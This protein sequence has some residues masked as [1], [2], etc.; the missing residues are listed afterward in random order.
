MLTSEHSQETLDT[1]L[2]PP[3]NEAGI[4]DRDD[5]SGDYLRMLG[6]RTYFRTCAVGQNTFTVSEKKKWRQKV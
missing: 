2:E 3:K 5:S 4:Q 6:L 1:D